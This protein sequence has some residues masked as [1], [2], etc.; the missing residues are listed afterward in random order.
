MIKLLI[1]KMKLTVKVDIMNRKINTIAFIFLFVFLISA[2]SA[3]ESENETI[4][5]IE[6]PDYEDLCKVSVE[7]N[8]EL[9]H[10]RSAADDPD[11]GTGQP[12]QG[13]KFAGRPKHN[14]KPQ[15][16]G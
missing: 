16:Q 3:A 2:V 8:D 4:S 10:Q 5:S 14:Y 6:Q 15:R 9:Q 12:P 1:L 13:G 11:K 7:N